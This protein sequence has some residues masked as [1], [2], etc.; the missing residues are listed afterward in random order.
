[1]RSGFTLVELLIV[2]AIIGVL[3]GVSLQAL[4]RV[5]DASGRVSCTC[6][7]R[8][9]GLAAKNYEGGTGSLPCDNYPQP[10][11][12]FLWAI[13]EQMEVPV[14]AGQ[15]QPDNEAAISQALCPARRQLSHLGPNAAPS[16]YGCAANPIGKYRSIVAGPVPVSSVNIANTGGTG[17]KIM[18]GHL[19]L[20]PADYVP[21]TGGGNVNWATGPLSR[22]ESP[23]LRDDV[24]TG[25]GLG[26]P[27]RVAAPFLFADGSVQ[28]LGYSPP[29]G[30]FPDHMWQTFWSYQ[31][32]T[33][34]P[35]EYEVR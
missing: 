6:K 3:V 8:Q 10:G 21:G 30:D 16:D 4:N 31:D 1:M 20:D 26:A 17:N 25:T 23:F 5:S 12:S 33:Q 24:G 18:V 32:R 13:R 2:V 7:L 28:R 19:G 22:K 29:D 9:I 34:I 11:M 15:I 14:A 35:S 27:H